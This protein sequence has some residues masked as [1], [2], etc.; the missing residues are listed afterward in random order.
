MWSQRTTLRFQPVKE[1]QDA[2]LDEARQGDPLRRYPRSFREL[3]EQKLNFS[4]EDCL[5][6]GLTCFCPGT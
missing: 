4:L 6:W 1:G 2:L 5:M 3:L